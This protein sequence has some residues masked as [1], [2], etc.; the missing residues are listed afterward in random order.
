MPG[1]TLR[2]IDSPAAYTRGHRKAYPGYNTPHVKLADRAERKQLK[3]AAEK[4]EKLAKRTH[5][6]FEEKMKK[7]REANGKSGGTRR[8]GRKHRSTRRR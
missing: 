3:K 7:W 1:V 5:E 6:L 2:N 8:R 4:A